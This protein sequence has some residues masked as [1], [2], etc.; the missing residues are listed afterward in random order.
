MLLLFYHKYFWI[1]C[2]IFGLHLFLYFGKV[3]LI[4]Y[5]HLI[6]LVLKLINL[7][8]NEKKGLLGGG[9]YVNAFYRISIE[10]DKQDREFSIAIASIADSVGIALAGFTSIPTHN[11]I[12]N[13]GRK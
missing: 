10:I 11:S 13:L 4:I 9:C 5:I 3:K 7:L 12:C 6:I 8:L 1:G 2:L